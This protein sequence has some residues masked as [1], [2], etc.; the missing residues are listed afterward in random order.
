MRN[1]VLSGLEDDLLNNLVAS[2]SSK[3]KNTNSRRISIEK[4]KSLQVFM[5]DSDIALQ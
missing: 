5:P 3:F 1:Y 4:N 2:L